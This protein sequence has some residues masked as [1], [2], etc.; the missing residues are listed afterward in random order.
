MSR[1][2]RLLR[3]SDA[4]RASE[5][6]TV[7]A[8]AETLD[9]SGR[10]IRRDLATLREQG[11]AIT[12]E[13]GRG[14]GLR[15]EGDRGVTSVHLSLEEVVSLWLA[16]RLSQRTSTLPWSTSASTALTKLLASLPRS[17]SRALTALCRRVIIGPPPTARMLESLGEVP[18]EALA[19]FETCFTSRTAMAFDYRGR[20]GR[21][22]S[23][24]VEPHGLLVQTPLWYVLAFDLDAGA[25]RMFRM[26]RM[27]RLRR[28]LPTPFEPRRTVIDALLEPG[29]DWQP[30][31]H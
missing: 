5:T 27:S 26:D 30:L 17:R 20:D 8:L 12:G 2:L 15:L 10:T 24:R 11:L 19:V 16:A 28:L 25:P 18:R 22:S 14:G 21:S 4:L 6:T 31:M 13:S 7:E 29:F 9:V 23:R 3:L 1:A